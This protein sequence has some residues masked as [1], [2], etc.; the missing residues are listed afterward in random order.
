MRVDRHD[1]AQ[2]TFLAALVASG[3]LL[4]AW[5]WLLIDFIAVLLP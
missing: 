3:F 5:L 1:R 4:S 2:F